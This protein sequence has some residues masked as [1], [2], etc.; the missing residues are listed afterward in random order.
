[1]SR[2]V[3]VICSSP[4]GVDYPAKDNQDMLK[5]LLR[6]EEPTV[7][8]L[9]GGDKGSFPE[10]MPK[11]EYDVIL[12]AGCNSL[13]FI[14]LL[15]DHEKSI[16]LLSNSLKDKGILLVTE[17]KDFITKKVSQKHYD[18][19]KLTVMLETIL[20]HH[21][22]LRVQ[23]PKNMEM[24]KAKI[25]Y[26]NTK[27]KAQQTK[28]D[29]YIVYQHLGPKASPAPQAQKASPAAEAQKED[30]CKKILEKLKGIVSAGG[31]PT[32]VM[33]SIKDVLREENVIATIGRKGTLKKATN[34]GNINALGG[35]KAC[36][37]KLKAVKAA[38]QDTMHSAQERLEEI[39]NQV[40]LQSRRNSTVK[41]S[42]NNSNS[43]NSA[44]TPQADFFD[45]FDVNEPSSRDLATL[46][47][48]FKMNLLDYEAVYVKEE[49]ET[50]AV[51]KTGAE[52]TTFS[53]EQGKAIKE[54]I[55]RKMVMKNMEG[56]PEAEKEAAVQAKI[57]EEAAKSLEDFKLL[58]G[59]LGGC[60]D[61]KITLECMHASGSNSDCFFHSFLGATCEFYRMAKA[62]GKPYT[63]FVTRFREEIVPQII[64][65]FF[66]EDDDDKP[67]VTMSAEDLIQELGSPGQFLPDDL[68]TIIAYYYNCAILLV[69]PK[70]ADGIRVAPL[71][72]NDTDATYGI[73]NSAGVHF[74][75]LRIMGE[76]TYRLSD[77]QAKCLSYTYSQ[78]SG[79]T[80]TIDVKRFKEMGKVVPLNKPGANGTT[81]YDEAGMLAILSE[82]GQIRES[83]MPGDVTKVYMG[84][85]GEGYNE[86]K[87]AQVR[88]LQ[89]MIGRLTKNYKDRQM[90]ANAKMA[91]E[92]QGLED[93]IQ[94]LQQRI[95]D[96]TAGEEDI[97]AKEGE[98]GKFIE[99]PT[100]AQA[101]AAAAAAKKAAAAAKKTAKKSAKSGGRRTARKKQKAAKT[102]RYA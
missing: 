75:P 24:Y 23:P 99:R 44:Y 7:D 65:F 17:S 92:S 28:K 53:V 40:G 29:K 31:A 43:N 81:A 30:T 32:R 34:T 93:S 50:A 67:V 35:E 94:R 74:E 56:K 8:F 68:Y 96:G 46:N 102:R 1:M 13:M 38:L 52:K 55:I 85:R 25:A 71:I 10:D 72:G 45:L 84:L 82:G 36:K 62:T 4:E 60:E 48:V 54:D 42:S 33:E 51:L 61:V 27:F 95:V 69:R 5:T 6:G 97:Q 79:T 37:E 3:L 49:V 21:P 77:A 76:N 57:T 59:D 15:K 14:G 80:A 58:Y 73:S 70:A 19:H 26:W 101:A 98:V 41:N 16:D 86:G 9:P 89:E 22:L 63:A 20:E 2:S 47:E 78:L 87:T 39:K 100:Q 66:A 18:T 11:K 12:F 83:D 64:E 90:Y 88:R 91:P